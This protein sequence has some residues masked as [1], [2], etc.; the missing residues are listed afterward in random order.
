MTQ[1]ICYCA[2]ILS[3]V[4]IHKIDEHPTKTVYVQT[5]CRH[6]HTQFMYMIYIYLD[7]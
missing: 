6:T 2:I 5:C 1:N 4:I 3:K 7:Q